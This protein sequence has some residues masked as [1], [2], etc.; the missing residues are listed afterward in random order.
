MH[1]SSVDT[2]QVPQVSLPQELIASSAFLLGRLG[3][4]VKEQT[5]EEFE[6]AGFSPYHYSVLA[7]LD[8]GA[9]ATQAE[10]ADALRLDRS[11]LVGLLDALEER[12]LVERRRDPNDRRC[13]TV[14]LTPAGRRQLQSLRKLVKRIEDEIFAP[15]DPEER[16]TLYALLLR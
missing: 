5:L 7:L 6:R 4:G 16:A 14:S 3:Y 9:R 15:L 11:Q 10:I 2:A 8:E 1:P 13:H 12:D